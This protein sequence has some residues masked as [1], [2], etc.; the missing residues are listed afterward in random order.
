MLDVGLLHPL[1]PVVLALASRLSGLFATA[2]FFSGRYI[3][4][5]VKAALVLCLSLALSPAVQAGVPG[6]ISP[7]SPGGLVAMALAESFFGMLAGFVSSLVFVA[8]QVAGQIFDSEMGYGMTNVLDPAH[9]VQVPLMGGFF[10]L[11]GLALFLA[12]DGHHFL[13]AGVLHTPA[14]FPVRTARWDQGIPQWVFDRFCESFDLGLR[15]ALP[16]LVASLLAACAM[17]IVSRAVTQ[18]NILVM[19]LPIRVLL[20]LAVLASSIGPMLRALAG[21]FSTSRDWLFAL[22][23]TLAP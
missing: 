19:G 3:P 13:L 14:A 1:L 17:G 10:Q 4:V 15:L 2:P 22:V 9:G 18:L 6:T 23:E 21:A 11:C 5:Q 12:M 7:S 16:V 8:V 20:G